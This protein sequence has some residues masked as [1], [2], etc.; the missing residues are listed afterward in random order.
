MDIKFIE[1]RRRFLDQFCKI[2]GE[3]PHLYYSGD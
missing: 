2:I 3:I 1:E